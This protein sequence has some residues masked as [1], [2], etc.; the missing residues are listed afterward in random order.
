MRIVRRESARRRESPAGSVQRAD[1]EVRR[2]LGVRHG[3]PCRVPV[4]DVDRIAALPPH[5]LRGTLRSARRCSDARKLL[6]RVRHLHV[7]DLPGHGV[8]LDHEL[9]VPRA[10]HDELLHD[11]EHL[12]DEHHEHLDDQLD[13][14]SVWRSLPPLPRKLSSRPAVY[15]GGHRAAVRLR[16]VG[17]R[18]GR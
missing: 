7:D 5:E 4:D 11:D 9:D 2:T 12:D 17:Y 13:S 15:G 10:H 1:R 16:S 14:P 18:C 3:Q 8:D 6:Y